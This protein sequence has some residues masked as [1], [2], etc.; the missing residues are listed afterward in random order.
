[1]LCCNYKPI[2]LFNFTCW[3][4]PFLPVRISSGAKVCVC[5]WHASTIWREINALGVFFSSWRQLSACAQ[6]STGESLYDEPFRLIKSLWLRLMAARQIFQHQ[7]QQYWVCKMMSK[8]SHVCAF[9]AFFMSA[10][11]KCWNQTSQE[12]YSVKQESSAL[13]FRQSWC[14]KTAHIRRTHCI[15]VGDRRWGG[16]V[17]RGWRSYFHVSKS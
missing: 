8:N 12:C 2:S 11:E 9:W 16:D 17:R 5:E 6:D 1:M 3:A 7:E 13:A 14:W 10:H 4:N 15:E